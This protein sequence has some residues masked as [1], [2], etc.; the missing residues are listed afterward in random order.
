MRDFISED[1]LDTFEGWLKYQA[2]GAAMPPD[3]LAAWR[4]DY[5]KRKAASAANPKMGS[6]KLTGEHLYAVAVRDGADLWLTLWVKRSLKGEFFVFH[7]RERGPWNPH[8][9]YHRDGTVHSKSYGKKFF[10]RQRQPL[11]D[12]FSGTEHLGVFGGHMPKTV[13]AIC[14]PKDFSG[15]IEIAP[16]IL[17]PVH[18][19][20]AVDLVAPGCEPMRDPVLDHRLVESK[21]FCDAVPHVVIRV[22][23]PI[24]K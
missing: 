22:Y 19:C 7:P 13:G 9:S 10:P 15:V 16:G 24:S 23:T 6:M 20:V 5:E 2:V 12:S 4:D 3:Q 21:E 11:T 14:A 18:G 1:D 17:G 8:T